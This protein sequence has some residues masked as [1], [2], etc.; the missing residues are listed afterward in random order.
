MQEL[1]GRLKKPH[2]GDNITSERLT[3][4]KIVK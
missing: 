2:L 4:N 3:N 1:N